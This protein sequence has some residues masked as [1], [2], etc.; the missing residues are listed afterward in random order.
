VARFQQVANHVPGAPSQV[1]TISVY[2][3]ADLHF[4]SDADG[5]Y[6]V[7]D[8]FQEAVETLLTIPGIEPLSDKPTP[9]RS[10]KKEI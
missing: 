9:K 6:E 4:V 1:R 10:S 5:V 8:D 7:P 3:A 2:G